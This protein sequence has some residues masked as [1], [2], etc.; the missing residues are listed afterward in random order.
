[1]RGTQFGLQCSEQRYSTVLA[2]E[3][4]ALIQTESQTNSLQ[5]S[6]QSYTASAC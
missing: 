3:Y 5:R 2:K 4:Q 6:I 1:V